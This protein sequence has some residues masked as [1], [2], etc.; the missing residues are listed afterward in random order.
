[1]QAITL[2]MVISFVVVNLAVD[3]LYWI[4]DPRIRS[5]VA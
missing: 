3:I 5:E 4:L 1:V 2:I